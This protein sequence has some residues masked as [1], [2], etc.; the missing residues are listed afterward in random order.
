MN[1]VEFV[2]E[3]TRANTIGWFKDECE[4]WSKAE[5]YVAVDGETIMT[6]DAYSS[7][8]KIRRNDGVVYTEEVDLEDAILNNIESIKGKLLRLRLL[9]V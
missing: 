2:E 3:S 6:Y 9:G 1:V 5:T 7:L 4:H 8:L